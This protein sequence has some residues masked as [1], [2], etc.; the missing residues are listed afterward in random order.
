MGISDVS[1]P[2]PGALTTAGS[3]AEEAT[4]AD[5]G[6]KHGL[7]ADA[8][9]F[10]NIGD[11]ARLLAD[12]TSPDAT[13]KHGWPALV[14]AAS[15]G[16]LE[17]VRALLRAGAK[18]EVRDSTYSGTALISS[19]HYGHLS[20]MEALLERGA[21][22]DA[23]DSH[24][25]TALHRAARGGHVKCL[26]RLLQAG[27]DRT[28]T[29]MKNQTALDVAQSHGRVDM[30]ALLRAEPLSLVP[31]EGDSDALHDNDESRRSTPRRMISTRSSRH[32]TNS[33]HMRCVRRSRSSTRLAKEAGA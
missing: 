31:D 26:N 30:V 3:A 12:G 17:V 28:R 21:D 20:C 18:L 14:N 33:R 2:G 27:A 4:M 24:G 10:G 7:L 8:G 25:N 32:P 23:A 19:A 29:N 1:L 9:R 15:R 6:L 5:D 22:K 13:C 11:V 16:H